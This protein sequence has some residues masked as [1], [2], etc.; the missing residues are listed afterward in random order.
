[1]SVQRQIEV[2]ALHWRGVDIEITFEPKW[3]GIDRTADRC[4]AHLTLT[5]R[6]PERAPLPVTETGYLSHFIQPSEIEAAGGPV[7]YL[8]GWLDYMAQS[9]DWIT[10]EQQSRQLSL[11]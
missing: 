2:H 4:V 1:M 3:L 8:Q 7:A 9:R 6:K 11:F 10:W 5:A